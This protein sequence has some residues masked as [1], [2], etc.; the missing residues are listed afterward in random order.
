MVTSHTLNRGWLLT[1][2]ATLMAQCS[3]LVTHAAAYPN[4]YPLGTDSASVARFPDRIAYARSIVGYLNTVD[5]LIPELSPDEQ[6]WLNREYKR[7]AANPTTNRVRDITDLD[8]WKQMKAK[9]RISWIR[10]HIETFIIPAETLSVEFYAWY[11]MQKIFDQ[12]APL[13]DDVAVYL[14]NSGQLTTAA[15]WNRIF[16]QPDLGRMKTEDPLGFKGVS[17][18]IRNFVVDSFMS[19]VIK[20]PDDLKQRTTPAI[21]VPPGE[22]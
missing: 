21:P 11:H 6:A 20:N 7:L 19:T 9:E 12:D 8:K 22:K 15:I 1:V 2:M 4:N 13:I 16:G 3:C 5:S 14:F 18:C 17:G 10:N